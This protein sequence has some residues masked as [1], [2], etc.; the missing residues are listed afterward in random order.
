MPGFELE[1][2]LVVGLSSPLTV[3]DPHAPS[4]S[5]AASRQSASADQLSDLY[6]SGGWEYV[7][8]VEDATGDLDSEDHESDE[9]APRLGEAP[10]GAA[11]EQGIERVREALMTYLWPGL[12][13]KDDRR[14]RQLELGSATRGT[15]GS[16]GQGLGDHT[17]LGFSDSFPQ[18]E[19]IN[20]SSDPKDAQRGSRASNAASIPQHNAPPPSDTFS[21]PDL[22]S[23]DLGTA[24]H[25]EPDATDEALARAFLAQIAA[26][27]GSEALLDP[28]NVQTP[29]AI[30]PA[31]AELE[32]FLE[33]EDPAWPAVAGPQSGTQGVNTSVADPDAWIVSD[34]ASRVS[35]TAP[36]TAPEATQ[37]GRASAE[38]AFDDDFSDFV[39]APSSGAFV[40]PAA[41]RDE[42]TPAELTYLNAGLNLPASDQTLSATGQDTD[43][44]PTLAEVR[45]TYAAIFGVQSST[46]R[47]GDTAPVNDGDDGTEGD[48]AFAFGQA[49][50]AMQAQAARVRAIAD[51]ER[52]QHEA[53][54]VALAFG[55]ALG[56]VD[57]QI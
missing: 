48:A 27:T 19:D 44:L 22:R 43:T 23:L 18:D 37:Q 2:S 1:I 15:A 26:S 24:G 5:T 10:A 7:D 14:E 31:F 47:N 21:L 38:V 13:R 56:P 39:S 49:L 25:A 46:R 9:D 32:A 53:A 41:F 30:P 29:R 4:S 17:V 28:L 54:R 6:V 52:R 8:L 33:S 51:P 42:S 11:E 57:E 16:R 40:D 20:V 35:T 36:A 34:M 12:E 50:G 55:M 45:A 3:N